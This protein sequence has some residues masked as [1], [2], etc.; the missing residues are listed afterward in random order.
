[1]A[2]GDRM[3][4]WRK[5]RLVSLEHVVLGK[6]KVLQRNEIRGFSPV[7]SKAYPFISLRY[8]H[9]YLLTYPN[10]TF[11]FCTDHHIKLQMRVSEFSLSLFSSTLYFLHLYERVV[12][13]IEDF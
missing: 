5:S 8:I 12:T 9:S 4:S 10:V 11:V 6:E 7:L 13:N 2:F 3:M 1:M